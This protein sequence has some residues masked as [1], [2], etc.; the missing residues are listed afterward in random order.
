LISEHPAPNLSTSG[1]RI[2]PQRSLGGG[3]NGTLIR[4][5]V[6][7]ARCR[8]WCFYDWNLSEFTDWNLWFREIWWM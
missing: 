1:V 6:W 7:C 2:L 3:E 4:E 5:K 8:V